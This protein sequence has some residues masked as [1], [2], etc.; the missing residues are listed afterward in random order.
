M[1]F[2]GLIGAVVALCV[3]AGPSIAQQ[4]PARL[5][6][7]ASPA[8]APPATV[9]AAPRALVRDDVETWLDGFMATRLER[10]DVAG[11]VVVVVKDGSVLLQKG[12]GYAD[13][14]H[15]R[16]VDPDTTLFRPGSVSKLMTWTAVMQQVELG[17]IDL[18]RDVNA[19]LDFKIPPFHG[20]PVTMRNLMTHTPGFQ[21]ALKDL[22]L[23]DP[24]GRMPLGAFLRN[25]IPPRIY[26]PGQV[27]SYSN[28]GAALAGY[29]VERVSGQSFEDY[30][31]QHIFQP[32]GMRQ[33]TFREPL[34]AGLRAQMSSGYQAA[35]AAPMRYEM[36]PG[37]AGSAAV[38]AADMAKFMIAHLQN[39]EY[40][41]ARILKPETARMMHDTPL[42]TISP[43]LN[44]MMLGFW[45]MNRNGHRIIGHEGD[46]RFFHS[47]LKL[48]PDENVGVFVLVN[49]VGQNEGGRAIRNDLGTAFV[50][51]YF[52]GPTMQG[53]MAPD[54][55]L[56]HARMLAGTYSPSQRWQVGY[57]SLLD[58]G[59][60]TTVTADAVGQVTVSSLTGLNGRPL[61][62][63]EIAPFVWRE[64]NGQTL[65]AAKAVGG[66][67]VLW[68]DDERAP[69]GAFVPTPAG[70]RAAWVLPALL[71]SMGILLLTTLQWPI[72]ALVRRHYGASLPFQ[73]GV[74][75]ARLWGRVGS[76]ASLTLML[77]WFATLGYIVGAFSFTSSLD[78]WIRILQFLSLV[79][80]PAAAA[81]TA[82]NL[83][84]VTRQMTGQRRLTWIWSLLMT[85]SA[86]MLLYV[87]LAFELIGLS[88]AL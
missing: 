67:V 46:T 19:Y 36:F 86:V 84:V 17:R 88:L 82:W 20:R 12:Y 41:G 55:A 62:F 9:S 58:L 87:A 38:T 57:A 8:K 47:V 13:I 52:P 39:G 25:Q 29:I 50:D 45:G 11:A 77:I 32:L 28:Y 1:R 48:L 60:Q 80:F 34:P 4:E 54:M 72:G 31:D 81:V 27:P 30:T 35:S 15:R 69:T 53:K 43:V 16:P 63:V 75:R 44:R 23:F 40:A 83:W 65:L 42:T 79:I 78:P 22:L 68:S 33:S 14:A 51:R 18:D 61:T 5:S 10:S 3:L 56:D 70:R 37:P 26:E 74:A 2:R 59:L 49:S 7:S 73:G 66:K 64:I 24:K 76:A 71:V 21:E 6:G 85:I